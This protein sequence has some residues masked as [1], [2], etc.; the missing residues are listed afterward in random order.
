MGTNYG[1][2]ISNKLQNKIL[3]TLTKPVHT[4]EVLARHAIWEQMVWTREGNLQ[5]AHLSKWVILEA[6]AALGADHDAPMQLMILDNEIEE[7]NYKQNN[8]VP[9]KMLDSEKTQ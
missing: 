6:A 3:V 4:L 7:R 8:E 2:G 9:I 1:Q 5:L